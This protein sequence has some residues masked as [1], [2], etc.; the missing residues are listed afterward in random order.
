[1]IDYHTHVG[2]AHHWGERFLAEAV[3]MRGSS[4]TLETT[5][6]DHR[7]AAS[8]ASNVIVLAFRSRHLGFDVPNEYVAEYCRTEPDKLIGFAS[9]DPHDENA[10]EELQYCYEELGLRGLKTSPIYQAYDPLDTRMMGIY[11]YCEENGLPILTHQGTTFPRRAPLRWAHPQQIEDVLLTFPRLRMIIA[12]L[13]H[14]WEVETI[15]L[16]RK[17]PHLYADIS[18]LFYRP[19]QMYSSLTL[20]KEYG[21]LDKLLFGTDYPVTTIDETLAGL[22]RLVGYAE[23]M[24]FPTF[25]REDIDRL[26]ERDVLPELGLA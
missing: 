3:R 23:Q 18:A 7:A 6:D 12:H 11:R 22:D 20:C 9:V 1:M 16:L 10:L 25:N 17:H 24:P 8:K 26:V 5:F 2:E 14:P 4:P 15:A 21:V 19:F 13:G